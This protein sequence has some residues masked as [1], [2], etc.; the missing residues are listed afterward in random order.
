MRS[1]ICSSTMGQTTKEIPWPY[2]KEMKACRCLSEL[3]F[4]N[5][6]YRYMQFEH[7]QYHSPQM[8]TILSRMLTV[9]NCIISSLGFPNEYHARGFTTKFLYAFSTFFTVSALIIPGDVY[10]SYCHLNIGC[11]HAYVCA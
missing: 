6:S 10:I 3:T 8:D 7:H 1:V 9:P 5:D 11:I 4:N 2:S